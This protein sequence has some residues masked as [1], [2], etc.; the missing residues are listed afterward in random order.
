[1]QHDFIMRSKMSEIKKQN[2]YNKKQNR[3]KISAK[4]KSK[5]GKRKSKFG[6]GLAP[7]H[8]NYT[9]Y[10]TSS[11]L[12]SPPTHDSLSLHHLRIQ[13]CHLYSISKPFISF[14][15]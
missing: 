1:M 6:Q 3:Q 14:S 12:P 9:S 4:K 2:G 7:I 11:P 5:M 13:G 8:A 10:T 15:L